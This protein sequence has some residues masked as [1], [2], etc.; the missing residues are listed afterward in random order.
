MSLIETKADRKPMALGVKDTVTV[1]LPLAAILWPQVFVSEKSA[2]SFPLSVMLWT[3]IGELP[4]FLIVTLW[5]GPVVPAFC[6]PKLRLDAERLTYVPTP[7]SAI[8]CGLPLALSATLTSD[9]RV[10]IAWGVKLT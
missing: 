5:G 4:V 6:V 3:V 7:V 9:V 2:G 8:I 1:Q 10:L